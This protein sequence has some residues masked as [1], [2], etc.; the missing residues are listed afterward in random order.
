MVADNPQLHTVI[1]AARWPVYVHASDFGQDRQHAPGEPA[2]V[3]VRSFLQPALTDPADMFEVSLHA[4]LA[5]VMPYL[6]Q[7]L[8]LDAGAG[9]T[10]EQQAD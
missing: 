10:L 8:G 1:L 6:V 9:F 5:E 2:M 7:V 4:T 3:G